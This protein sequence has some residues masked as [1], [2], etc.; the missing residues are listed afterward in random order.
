MLIDQIHEQLKN[1]QLAREEV[2]VSTLRLLIS[3]VK[4]SEISKGHTLSDEEI[5]EVIAKEAKKRKES[6]VSFRGGGREELAQKE[7]AEL[8]ILET[9]LPQ[10]MSDEELTKLVDQSIT[11]IGASSIAD[12]GKV[13]QAVM[14]KAKGLADGNRVSSL[15]KTKLVE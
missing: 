11:E 14:A 4:N 10:Q 5:L 8:A 7:E 9:Y 3:E 2:K 1:A 15:V 12:M 13:M 6:I